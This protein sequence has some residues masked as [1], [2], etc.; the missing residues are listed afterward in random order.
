MLS[1]LIRKFSFI[2]L[3][4]CFAIV[5]LFFITKTHAQTIEEISN[6]VNV[7]NINFNVEVLQNGDLNI[8]ETIKFNPGFSDLMPV[9]WPIYAKKIKN[10]SASQNGQN[11]AVDKKNITKTKTGFI[12]I[13]LLTTNNELNIFW[14]QKSDFSTEDSF[15]KLRFVVLD[16]PT[17]SIDNLNINIDLSKNPENALSFYAIHGVEQFGEY[18]N[19]QKDYGFWAKGVTGFSTT[20]MIIKVPAN[21]LDV[22]QIKHGLAKLN[23]YG[24]GIWIIISIF[25]PALVLIIILAVYLRKRSLENINNTGEKNAQKPIDIAP[26]ILGVLYGQTFSGRELATIIINLAIKGY[27][28]IIEKDN[29][30]VFGQRKE[31]TGLNDYETIIV[32]ELFEGQF[33]GGISNIK[34]EA[35]E[36]LY[37]KT[38]TSIWQKI[39]SIVSSRGWFVKNPFLLSFKIRL[40][41]ALMFLASV[42]LF[43]IVPL[44]S[45][46]EYLVFVFLG[47]TIASY[48]VYNMA[49]T[50]PIR[51]YLGKKEM[52]K[53]LV[54]R[55]YLVQKNLTVDYNEIQ[56]DLF[57]DNLP[58]AVAL[59]SE[60]EWANNFTKPVF[61]APDWYVSQ[62]S[63]NNLE[64]FTQKLYP[65]IDS[66]SSLIVS[67]KDPGEI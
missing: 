15:D 47:T 66:L 5:S 41:G 10:V 29:G 21:F 62:D 9:S 39:Y 52:E 45:Q 42:I 55:N 49:K 25:I 59:R 26:E 50:F 32:N 36:E 7:N 40:L 24:F 48:V 64:E 33:S 56:G 63:I 37:S 57:I 38:L 20:S 14:Q 19:P 23:E 28:Y 4:L 27:I 53:W 46:N 54:F 61:K 44:F 16:Q 17:I 1:G 67:L 58:Y 11:I 18:L 3:V 31:F 43:F 12:I 35:K 30:F 51:T 2:S 13:N 22:S 34:N 60:R 8:S 6:G 65:L